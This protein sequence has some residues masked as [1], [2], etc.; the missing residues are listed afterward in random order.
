MLERNHTS[1]INTSCLN[2][3]LDTRS[4]SSWMFRESSDVNSNAKFEVFSFLT[5]FQCCHFFQPKNDYNGKEN[6]SFQFSFHVQSLKSLHFGMVN[7]GMDLLLYTLN[8]YGTKNM[9]KSVIFRILIILVIAILLCISLWY[10][11]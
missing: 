9:V 6:S 3:Y 5:I 4:R 10:L 7:V 2:T 1:V 8:A 11:T